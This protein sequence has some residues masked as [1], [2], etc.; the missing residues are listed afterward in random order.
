MSS[1]TYRGCIFVAIVAL[2]WAA[3]SC[4]KSDHYCPGALLDNCNYRDAIEACTRNEDCS[5][6]AAVC[7]V[8]GSRMCVQC[9]A[10]DQTSACTGAT[11]VCGD[12]H[13]C[14]G[15]GAH[16]ECAGSEVCLPTGSCGGDTNVAYVDPAGTDNAS[17]TRATPCTLLSKALATNRPY[18]KLTGTTDEAVIIDNGRVITFLADPGA[19]L[20]RSNG[21]GAI[22]TVRDSGTSLTVYDLTI[23]VDNKAAINSA[24]VVCN[25]PAFMAPNN[26]V[27]RNNL[28]GSTTA[29]SA[30]T[31]MGG[32]AYPSSRIQSDVAGLMFEH[33]DPPGT[34]S[35][36]LV[37][38]SSA[39]DQATTPSDITVD[40]EGDTRPQGSQKDIGA[41]EVP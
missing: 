14:R 2:G 40:H 24:G 10:P 12:D 31:T 9:L 33:P 38:G 34:L 22:V 4:R 18:V 36:R 5:A 15:C 26:I 1:F 7:D 17:C 37:R 25:V 3:A 8:G 29:P 39:I 20:T 28:A 27:A 11:P 21:A 6:P 41:D 35:Y 23:I 13:V 19:K 30:Q 32:C 16:A